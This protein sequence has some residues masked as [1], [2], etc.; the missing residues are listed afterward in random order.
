MSL[1]LFRPEIDD[2]HPRLARLFEQ[3][4]RDFWN[5]STAIDW[6]QPLKLSPELRRALARVFSMIYY[7]ERAALE[8]SAQLVAAVDDEDA[9]FVLSAQVIEEAKHVSAFRRLLGRLDAIHPCSR[10]ARWV[11]TDLVRVRKPVAKLLGMQLLVENVAN[12]L[13]KQIHDAVDEPLVRQVLDYAARDE[14]KHTALAVA[15][16][17]ELL[18][19]LSWLE[20]QALQARE[21]YWQFCIAS[22]VWEHRRDAAALGIDIRTGLERALEAQDRLIEQMGTRRGIFKSRALER[23][24][25]S[26]YPER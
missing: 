16:L 18:P 5:D 26:F 23:L 19:K 12:Q 21:L 13:F 15:Y 17:P 10:Y 20:V 14:R 2:H 24:A 7:G 11:L 4:K 3:A 22:A 6:E 25:L 8:V 9:K 1:D